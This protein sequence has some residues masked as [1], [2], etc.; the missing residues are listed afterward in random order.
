M[1]LAGH[2]RGRAS[3][4]W[5]LLI[6]ENRASY[7]VAVKAL[8]EKLD[9]G[10]QTFAALDF[11]HTSQQSSESVSDYITTLEKVFQTGF[12]C[13]HL[14]IETREI[15]LYGQLQEGLLYTLLE[16]PSI[17]GAQNYKELCLAARR[18]ERRLAELKK[19]QQ[20][21]RVQPPPTGIPT[22]SGPANKPSSTTQYWQRNYRRT[23][24]YY[25]SKAQSDK[26]GT[27]QQKQLRCYICDSPNH[28]ARQCKQ[29]KTESTG[30]KEAQTKSG[31]GTKMIQTDSYLS[32]KKSGSRCVKVMVEGAPIVGLIDTGPDITIMRGDQFYDMVKQANLNKHHLKPT[33]QRACA[34]DQKPIT[35]DCQIDMKITF[36][37]KTIVST[38]FVKLVAPDKLLLSENVCRMLGVV[39][40]HPDVQPV[41]EPGSAS[42]VND[43]V[44]KDGQDALK[45]ANSGVVESNQDLLDDESRKPDQEEQPLQKVVV[46]TNTSSVAVVKLLSAVRLP[47]CHSAV[48]PVQVK[49]VTG[50]MLIEQC[51]TLNDCLCIDQSLVE[52]KEDGVTTL[53]ITNNG[54][55]PI[56]Y[57]L[58]LS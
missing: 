57:K 40:Y 53:W 19:K 49:G 22:N 16:S 2:L 38:V 43:P 44:T 13:E 52:A 8:R 55:L 7:Q 29:T 11:H 37:E 4:E 21:L 23:G 15:L 26:D 45:P 28:L 41:D 9:T 10:N 36:G 32:A 51:E 24:N 6:P 31:T 58:V 1:Q 50:S 30:K 5:K 18:E 20:Y 56:S 42:T 27:R 14:S 33:E 12:G 35:L 39:S 47:A 48:I 3:Q 54:K 17:S 34:Y 46:E 25:K